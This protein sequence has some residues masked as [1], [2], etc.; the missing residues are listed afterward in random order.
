M[1]YRAGGIYVLV[2]VLFLA[3]CGGARPKAP[4]VRPGETT[5]SIYDTYRVS[6]GDTLFSIAW[7]YGL[8]YRKLAY[9][10]N[11][12][13]PYR[14]F[15]SQDLL[16]REVPVPAPA[17]K[18]SIPKRKAQAPTPSGS[19]PKIIPAGKVPAT[20]RR[21]EPS[22]GSNPDLWRWPATGKVV[23]VYGSGGAHKGIDI[24]GKKGEPVY[25]SAAG[26]V[27]YAGDG[28]LG[29]GNL[30]IVKHSEQY[31]SAY[32]HNRQLLVEEGASVKAG[33]K[34]AEKGDSGTNS[35]KLHFEIRRDGKPIDPIR[36]L[37][38]R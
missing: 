33:Q 14:I 3:S 20:P 10:N 5:G 6:P 27:V 28:I 17:A 37:P 35:V 36:L 15:P 29:Y 24:G 21:T 31:L 19:K 11:I 7:R 16:L 12:A 9:A 1:V 23:G 4:V 34:I 25:S 26:R 38:R 8:D 32:G 13:D 30:L 22:V 2:F 18:S